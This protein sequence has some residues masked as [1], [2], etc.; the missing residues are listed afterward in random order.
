MCNN[1][2]YLRFLPTSMK[3][4]AESIGLDV[5]LSVMK[6]RGGRYLDVVTGKRNCSVKKE[7]IKSLGEKSA[8]LLINEF[9]GEHIYIPLFSALE[10]R[11]TRHKRNIE[12]NARLDELTRDDP[13]YRRA[14]EILAGEF[15]L[16]DRQIEKIINR[17]E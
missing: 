14:I 15:N 16:S 4:M 5:T 12:I 8:T 7:L 1:S 9:T 10:L 13:N 3:H 17:I 2:D 6:L 11:V